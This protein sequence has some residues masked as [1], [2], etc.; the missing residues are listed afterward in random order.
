MMIVATCGIDAIS[1]NQKVNKIVSMP[2]ITEDISCSLKIKFN[3][4]ITNTNEKNLDDHLYQLRG[5]RVFFYKLVDEH[6]F[7]INIYIKI[8]Q[9]LKPILIRTLINW[10]NSIEKWERGKIEKSQKS[11]YKKDQC[12]FSLNRNGKRKDQAG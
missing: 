8:T 9:R 11:E 7:G 4:I 5:R 6:D 12:P 1:I 2:Y 10:G 3:D